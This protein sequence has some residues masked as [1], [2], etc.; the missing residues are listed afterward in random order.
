MQTATEKE[1]RKKIDILNDKV[2]SLRKDKENV[3][4]QLT[5]LK[6]KY[7]KLEKDFKS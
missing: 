4:K 2:D 5:N 1:Y 3:E 7:N 6:D